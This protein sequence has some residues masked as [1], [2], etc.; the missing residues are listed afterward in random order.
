M[1]ADRADSG[2]GPQRQLIEEGDNL[3]RPIGA[4]A[5]ERPV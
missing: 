4:K 2:L 1:Y 3:V 5:P